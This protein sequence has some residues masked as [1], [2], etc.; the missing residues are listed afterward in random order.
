MLMIHLTLGL[1]LQHL[2][3]SKIF[4]R[5]PS[6]SSISEDLSIGLDALLDVCRSENRCE[7][8]W[9]TSTKMEE[10]STLIY[11]KWGIKN[12]FGFMD[13]VTTGEKHLNSTMG[14]KEIIQ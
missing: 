11:N 13:G 2:V 9:P 3:N 12:C 8:E 6:E 7:I 10:C 5:C 14:G 4:G 1:T